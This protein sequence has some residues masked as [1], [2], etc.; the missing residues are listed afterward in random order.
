MSSGY[1]SGGFSSKHAGAFYAAYF[2]VLGVLLPYLG[3]Y[4]QLRGVGAVGIGLITAAVSLAKLLY[5]PFVGHWVD[6]GAWMRGLL[7]LHAVLAAACAA[8]VWWLRG[9]MALGLAFFFL[10]LGYATVL[11]LVEAAILERIPPTRYGNVRVWGSVGFIVLATA[12][13][14]LLT[15]PALLRFPV[16]LAGILGV[17]VLTCGPFEEGARPRHEPSAGG[18]LP[19]AVWALLL[20]LTLHQVAHGPYYAF[21][22]ITLGKEGYSNA[23]IGGLWSFAVLA[24][25]LAF[26]FGGRLEARIGLR[27]LLGIALVATPFR[28]LLVSWS[29]A[30]PVL[31]LAQAAHA[32]TFAMA[33]LAGIQLVQRAAPPG[34]RRRV[35]AL[36]SGLTFGLGIVLGSALAGPLYAALGGRGTFAVAAAFSGLLFVA[37]LPLAPHLGRCPAVSRGGMER[38]EL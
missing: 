22:S 20:L 15:G 4:L 33:H 24:E 6:R 35:Q 25:S 31:V 17:L 12:V 37:W 5:A 1:P 10:G 16:Y 7:T 8:A 19:V 18:S 11:P 34:T 9:T 2:G 14:P 38:P 36:Y 29:G 32:L 30:L 13:A 3:P 26:A 21:F 28:W 27:R 23:A